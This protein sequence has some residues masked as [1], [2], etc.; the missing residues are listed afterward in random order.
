MTTDP[1][2]SWEVTTSNL[3]IQTYIKNHGW[4]NNTSYT[5]TPLYFSDVLSH[6]RHLPHHHHYHLLRAYLMPNTFPVLSA[7]STLTGLILTT[8]Q[9][10]TRPLLFL[11][12]R[13]ENWGPERSQDLPLSHSKEE[14]ELGFKPGHVAAACLITMTTR[15]L[16]HCSQS[17][18]VPP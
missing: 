7:I 17:L 1:P 5:N 13:W 9:W 6:H 4:V 12:Y 15:C 16:L 10:S 3:G 14:V 18:K 2:G 8:T 11:F